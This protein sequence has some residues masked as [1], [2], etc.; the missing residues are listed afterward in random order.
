MTEHAR[1]CA[2][3]DGWSDPAPPLRIF[4]NVYDVGTCGITVLLLT[5]SSGHVLIDAATADAAD[6]VVSNI[7]ML[8]F[9][10]RDVRYLLSS[11][12]HIDHA[13]GLRAIK[14]ATGARMAAVTAARPALESGF[15]SPEDPQRG[16]MARYQGVR[17]DR[18]LRD[19]DVVKLG[20]LRL[21][22][23][24]TPGHSPGGASWTWRSCDGGVCHSMAY[25]DS[26]SAVS[27][28]GY[29]FT[30]HPRYVATFRQTLAKI[31]GLQCDLIVT[32]HPSASRLYERLAGDGPLVDRD[33]CRNYA[34]TGRMRLDDRLA[35]E[36]AGR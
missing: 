19:G 25:V 8:G 1:R 6:G 5:G 36:R 22:V 24:T 17:I 21:T 26:V 2:G 28:D 31:E 18:L 9:D 12:E 30:D 7:R 10:P 33:A 35:S 20:R 16:A 13:G 11:H 15:A 27:A 4:A 32:P 23:H 29:R 3:R 14:L 34:A